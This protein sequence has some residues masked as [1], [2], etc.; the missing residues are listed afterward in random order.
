MAVIMRTDR[1]NSHY[2]VLNLIFARVLVIISLDFNLRPA[3]DAEDAIRR[4]IYSFG[5]FTLL[6]QNL[7]PRYVL[8]LV[9][10][11]ALFLSPGRFGLRFDACTGWFMFTGLVALA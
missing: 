9:P 4:C 2:T 6:T 7:I 5:A 11:V 8:W 1:I 10:L 3:Q